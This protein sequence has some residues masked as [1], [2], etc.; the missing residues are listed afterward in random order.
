MFFFVGF[1]A[2]MLLLLMPNTLKPILRHVTTWVKWLFLYRL[3]VALA[4]CSCRL[5][6]CTTLKRTSICV[7]VPLW[8]DVLCGVQLSAPSREQQCIALCRCC[9][10]HISLT[11][12]HVFTS[13]KI[14]YRWTKL[15]YLSCHITAMCLNTTLSS[16]VPIITIFYYYYYYYYKSFITLICRT[17]W[18]DWNHSPIL[19]YS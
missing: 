7:Q 9:L 3:I 8:V 15:I 14:N 10:S 1:F 2:C 11:S 19:N 18:E 6:L 17:T 4:G 5:L 16:A 13:I 12:S